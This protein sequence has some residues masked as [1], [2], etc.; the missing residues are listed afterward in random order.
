MTIPTDKPSH[1]PAIN[2]SIV[3]RELPVAARLAAAEAAGHTAVEFWWP[4]ETASPASAD[5]DQFVG[6]VKASGLQL[7]GLN[8]FAGD[9]P[10]GDRG[11]LSWPGRENELRASVT[12]AADIAAQ[13]GVQRFNALYGNRLDGV[14]PEIQDTVAETNL[15][16]ISPLLDA[17]GGVVMIEPVSG[18]PAYPVKTAAHAADVITR[19][20]DNDG[21]QNLGLVLDLYHLAVNGDDVRAAIATYGRDAA[22]VQ[23]ADAPGRGAPGTGD[24]PLADWV[25]Q[26]RAMGYQGGIA[27]EYAHPAGRP[28]TLAA[29]W[30][31]LA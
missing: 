19:A 6:E 21:P 11:I 15:R 10:A 13:L 29:E 22:H 7:V 16:Q 3:L 30:K 2:L 9:M 4:F 27:L 12:I 5:V 17:V 14:D 1:T 25:A 20:S 28:L 8:L 31:D 26:L 23:L 24:L 18:T